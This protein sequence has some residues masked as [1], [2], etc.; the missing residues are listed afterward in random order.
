M[1]FENI[2]HIHLEHLN[3]CLGDVGT[4]AILEMGSHHGC[5]RLPPTTTQPPLLIT[6]EGPLPEE[7]LEYIVCGIASIDRSSCSTQEYGC[8]PDPLEI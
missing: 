2:T 6:Q 5:L 7:T 3:G 4:T 8:T 1:S